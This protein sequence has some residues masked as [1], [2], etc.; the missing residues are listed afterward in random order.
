VKTWHK[1]A[2]EADLWYNLNRYKSEKEHCMGWPKDPEKRELAK[3]RSRESHER[4]YANHPEALEAMSQYTTQQ[5]S[6][7]EMRK[8]QS[9]RTSL[10]VGT[11]EAR[12]A[13]SERLQEFYSRAESDQIKQRSRETLAQTKLQA[14]YQERVNAGM[15]RVSSDPLVKMHRQDASKLLNADPAYRAKRRAGIIRSWQDEQKRDE[16]G[17]KSFKGYTKPTSIEI[18]VEQ[19]LQ[20]LDIPYESQWAMGRYIV[21][22]YIPSKRLVIECD[23]EYWHSKPEAQ[24]RDARKDAYLQQKGYTILRLPGEQIKRGDFAMLH[25]MLSM[26]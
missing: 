17:H 7:P 22:F 20:A 24:A 19:L 5:F 23:G 6:D 3:Q 15:K 16:R 11:P 26:A 21:D 4:Y 25:M 13:H 18:I 14:G 10:R 8:Q 12:K 9:E 2:S 1:V